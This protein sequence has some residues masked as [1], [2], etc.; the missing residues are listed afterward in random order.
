MVSVNTNFSVAIIDESLTPVYQLPTSAFDFSDGYFTCAIDWESLSISEGCYKLAVIDPCPCSQRGVTA[1]DFTSSTFEWVFSGATS[2]WT[3]G[4][5]TATYNGNST[6]TIS[7]LN[8]LCEGL[9]YKVTFTVSG[10]G[11]GE[12]FNVLL[13]SSSGATITSDGTYTQTITY[14]GG[15]NRIALVGNSTSG[16]QTFNVTNFEI[17]EHIPSSVLISNVI[18][19]RETWSCETKA[20]AICND[21]DSLGFGFANTGFKPLMRIPASLNRSSYPMQRESYDNSRGLK[22]NYY[23]R[24]RKSQELGFDGKE[25]MHDFAALFPISDHFYIDDLEYFVDEDEYPSISWGEF[26][27]LG[28]VTLN[29]GKK[30]QLI[31]NRRL[32]SSS[33][34]CSTE[35]LELL[36]E[37]GIPIKDEIDSIIITS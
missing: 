30:Q 5:G 26:D 31:E 8:V 3:I 2:D 22:Y 13:G 1:L 29:V 14:S 37:E 19:Y 20:L 16:T 36:D 25:F 9:T 28:G 35:S 17:E 32:T 4:G 12:E 34:G 27:D 24:L 7:L 18:E 10:M 33:I 21:S 15:T 11:S 6:D 23:G